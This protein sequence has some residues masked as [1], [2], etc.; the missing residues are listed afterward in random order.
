MEGGGQNFISR[1]REQFIVE[2]PKR[3]RH[4]SYGGPE[5]NEPPTKTSGKKLRRRKKE[6]QLS[7]TF[8]PM[9]CRVV[10]TSFLLTQFFC[11]FAPSSHLFLPPPPPSSSLFISAKRDLELWLFRTETPSSSSSSNSIHNT[12][13]RHKY[14]SR[15]ET[16]GGCFGGGMMPDLLNVNSAIQGLHSSN[17]VHSPRKAFWPHLK[18]SPVV[19]TSV[20][21]CRAP[22]LA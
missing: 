2:V 5:P 11:V 19:D 6:F 12:H 3:E 4:Y 10:V 16:V 21:N 8:L 1:T 9:V 17:N 15:E 13:T 14:E 22:F 18:C 20:N 7:F